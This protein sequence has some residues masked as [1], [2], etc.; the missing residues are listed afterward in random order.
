LVSRLFEKVA[1]QLVAVNRIRNIPKGE[2]TEAMLIAV[3]DTTKSTMATVPEICQCQ[4]NLL[5]LGETPSAELFEKLLQASGRFSA[6]VHAC[7]ADL[8]GQAK[9]VDGTDIDALRIEI[10]KELAKAFKRYS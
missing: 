8:S 10:I 1:F 4:A 2:L 6:D 3:V 7:L 5:L 9:A